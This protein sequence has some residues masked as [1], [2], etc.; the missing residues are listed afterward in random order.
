MIKRFFFNTYFMKIVLQFEYVFIQCLFL[1]SIQE[2][3]KKRRERH[4]CGYKLYI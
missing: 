1:F 2:E 3:K 4:V